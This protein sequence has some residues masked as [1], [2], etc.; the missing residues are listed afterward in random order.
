MTDLKERAA[1]VAWLPKQPPHLSLQEYADAI[2]RGAHLPTAPSCP[3]CGHTT[4]SEIHA[5][6]CGGGRDDQ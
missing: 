5:F 1:I 3:R 6:G 2:E 4:D